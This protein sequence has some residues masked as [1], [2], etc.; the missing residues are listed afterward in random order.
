MK[1]IGIAE[2]KS[3]LSEFFRIVQGGEPIGPAPEADDAKVR[4]RPVA[5]G[6]AA[7]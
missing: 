3:R 1:E 6:R 4:R 2:L 7:E 5:A